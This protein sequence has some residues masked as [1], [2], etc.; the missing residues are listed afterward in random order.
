RTVNGDYEFVIVWASEAGINRDITITQAD[1][2][3]LMRSKAAIYAGIRCM[4]NAIGM[5]MEDIERIY[6]AGAFGSYLNV[7]RAVEIG[8]LPDLPRERFVV[9]G[10]S[11]VKGARLALL[12]QQ[13]WDEAHALASR[14]TYLELSVEPSFMNE[15][16]SANFLPHTNLELFPS[17]QQT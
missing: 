9:L 17:V 11:S 4:L 10:N 14:M 12:S 6:V 8:L 1:I 2:K 13:A 7:R 16:I 3:N 5:G 15:F